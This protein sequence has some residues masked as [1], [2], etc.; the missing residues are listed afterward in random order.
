MVVYF[1]SFGW[2][3]VWSNAE[4]IS[5]IEALVDRAALCTSSSWSGMGH[6][7][8]SMSAFLFRRSW[9]CRYVSGSLFGTICDI[10]NGISEVERRMSDCSLGF[11]SR[12]SACFC[13]SDNLYLWA[14][15]GVFG[16]NGIRWLI[17]RSG[18]SLFGSSSIRMSSNSLSNR[19]R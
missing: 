10:A 18:G 11:T 17:S 15:Q 9:T 1:S 6:A 8:D 4:I 2:I 16:L 3:L 14:I 19:L 7:M 12:S 13:A 5:N